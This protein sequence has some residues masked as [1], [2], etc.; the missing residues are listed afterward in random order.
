MIIIIIRTWATAF[1]GWLMSETHKSA[2][3]VDVFFNIIKRVIPKKQKRK[4]MEIL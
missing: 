3:D 2:Y 1:N 4:K